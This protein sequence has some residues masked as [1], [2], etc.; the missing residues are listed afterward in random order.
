M[1]RKVQIR[2]RVPWKIKFDVRFNRNK[3][4]FKF[5]AIAV[6]PT[7]QF[8]KLSIFIKIYA[9]LLQAK[10]EKP[11]SLKSRFFGFFQELSKKRTVAVKKNNPDPQYWESKLLG[12]PLRNLAREE[13]S[14]AGCLLMGN[15]ALLLESVSPKNRKGMYIYVSS[16]LLFLGLLLK[17]HITG[18]TR[19]LFMFTTFTIGVWSI[20]LQF[21]SYL[22]CHVE[23]YAWK[24]FWKTWNCAS[25]SE[26]LYAMS[27]EVLLRF[28]RSVGLDIGASLLST[29]SM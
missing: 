18:K 28:Y 14:F 15:L 8:L 16:I 27:Q 22:N 17:K 3:F 9:F 26:C 23:G 2:K 7:S 4:N 6:K 21:A 10:V 11:K 5:K 1:N 12:S 19:S 25:G 13:S 24:F 20:V 29:N